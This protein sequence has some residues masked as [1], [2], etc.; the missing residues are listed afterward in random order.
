MTV[1]TFHSVLLA[2]LAGAAPFAAGLPASAAAKPNVIVIV[3]DDLGWPD[4]GVQGA[5]DLQTPNID[6]LARNGVRFTS[7]YVTAPLCSPSRAGLMTGRC[8]QRFGHEVNPGPTLEHN[9]AFGLPVT[10]STIA[11]RMRE[12]GYATGWVGKSHLGGTAAYHPLQRG[13]D[14]FFGFIEGE[15]H[16][17]L[18]GFPTNQIDPIV[19]NTTPVAETDYLTDAFS[20]DAVGF[21][22]SH[23]AQP[24]FLY[25]P[26][27]AVH[28]PLQA[29]SQYLARVT[30]TFA[31][32]NRRTNAA[33]L[34]ALDDAVGAILTN[35]AALG[36][37]TN[38]LIFFTSDNGAPSG[39]GIDVNGSV[40]APLRGFKQDMYEGGIRV[41]FI[42]HWPGR[43]PTN[44]VEDAMVS[45]L[46]FLPTSVAAAG[47]TIPDA[48]QLDG[49]DLLPYLL[50][51]TTNAPHPSLF[52]R[53]STVGA[54]AMRNGNWKLVKNGYERNWELYDLAADL[55]ESNNL[56]ALR[57]DLMRQLTAEYAA[58][59]TQLD[60]PRWGYNSLSDPKPAFVLEDIRL[61]A[62]NVSYLDPSFL[63]GGARIAF[64]DGGN[65]LWSGALDPL[66]GHFL[67]GD[68]RDS[69][70]DSGI[71]PLVNSLEGPEWGVSSNAPAVFYTKSVAGHRQIFRARL[72]NENGF[73][74]TQLTATT[75][76]HFNARVSQEA[77][78]ASVRMAFNVD[79]AMSWADET[80]PASALPIPFHAGG[81]RNGRWIPGAMDLAYGAYAPLVSA[82]TQV[83]RLN[84]ASGQPSPVSTNSDPGD[85]TDVWG[86]RAPEL[87]NELCYAALVD[88]GALA[89]YR[90]L[91]DN[92]N[93][94]FTRFAT[95]QAPTNAPHQFLYS[96]EPVQGLRGFNGV[97][98]FTCAAYANNDPLNP[99]DSSIWLFGL[100]PDANGPVVRRLD[101]GAADTNVFA[102]RREPKTMA[103]GREVFAYYTSVDGSSPAQLRLARTGIKRPDH[104]GEPT[105][106]TSLQFSRD[107]TAGTFDTNGTPLGGTELLHLVAH[108]GRLYAA[109]GS[110]QSLPYPGTPTN[111]PPGWVGAQFLVKDS[112]NAPWRVDAVSNWLDII[113]LHLRV[114]ALGD[115]TFDRDRDGGAIS[116]VNV[117]VAGLSDVTNVGSHLASARMR[118][119][120]GETWVDSHIAT[121]VDPADTISLG[122][123]PNRVTGA[124]NLFAGLSNGE[125]YRGW[126]DPGSNNLDWSH[127]A[128]LSNCGPV[129]AFADCNGSLYAACG[130]VQTSAG[131]GVTGGLFRRGDAGPSWQ[132]VYRWPYPADLVNAP[133]ENRLMRGLTTAPDPLGSSNEVLLAARAWPGVIERIEPGDGHRVTVELDVRDFFARQWNDDRVRTQGVI[134]AYSGFTPATNPVT[135]EHVH[136]VGLWIEDP[137]SAAPPF[138]G[139]HYLVRHSDATYEPADLA[140]FSPPLP[141][142]RRLRA[143]RC[144]APSPFAE[145]R[146]GVFFFGGYD[147]A[148]D[149]STN[150]AW[151]MRGAWSAWP[152]LL[153]T[154][155]NPPDWQLTW[156][157]AATNWLLEA[158]DVIGSSAN[159]QPVPG[160]P[161]RSPDV[162]TQ[163]AAPSASNSFFR[164]RGP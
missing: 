94:L 120:D 44:R 162:Q 8:Q 60:Q 37:A 142:G 152:E 15:H 153:L 136:L 18:P 53:I 1:R 79:G 17:V 131:A 48:W 89:I 9:P 72:T 99:G 135:G 148:A 104:P 139:S 52:W 126:Y 102:G 33:M 7:G 57:P 32:V 108:K 154:R 140:N 71:A 16:Y 45:T 101:E 87:D 96:L 164:L 31:D 143:T 122:F 150:T 42:L 95:F 56:A 2:A 19:S 4:L 62:T 84:T 118:R 65:N 105:G 115:F 10:E 149:V 158:G 25:L 80:A 129:T 49:V 97:S 78:N 147:T 134:I 55:G 22:Q 110:R 103:G 70:V 121:T 90:D 73:A 130:L 160:R 137:E 36:L 151:I 98:Y 61:G 21:I 43:L 5:A 64:Q 54:Q 133:P 59:N 157:T 77:T 58:W 116:N 35:L 125:I 46:D 29:P 112:A 38:T 13:F 63:P 91:H 109:N 111:L 6:S 11:D 24:F 68:G 159:W 123:H 47:G 117:L 132:L 66:G 113:R 93:G 107:Y 145:D 14:S 12:L 141:A 74:V 75:N 50:G 40:N 67:S 76:E 20:R 3:A 119:D 114:E 146:G 34:I 81:L 27:N 86:F 138:N 128:E 92:T 51:Q 163:I 82:T 127:S 155:P 100:G 23:A 161:T 156:P 26:F 83:A 28:F 106:F 30:N 88:H 85:K 41:P 39:S 144:I 124:D 69:W